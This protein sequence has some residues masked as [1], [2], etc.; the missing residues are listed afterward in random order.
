MVTKGNH[1]V[2]NKLGKTYGK[3][4]AQR[5][6]A[7][8][9]K[10]ALET[11]A[12][13]AAKEYLMEPSNLPL[14]WED[15][16]WASPTDLQFAP[17]VGKGMWKCRKCGWYTRQGKTTFEDIH[18]ID[19]DQG[20]PWC[21]ICGRVASSD[22]FLSIKDEEETKHRYDAQST[23]V[24][25]GSKTIPFKIQ[26]HDPRGL[27]TFQ[28]QWAKHEGTSP[29]WTYDEAEMEEDMF[30]L[31]FGPRPSLRSILATI[32][33]IQGDKVPYNGAFKYY[34][35]PP[36]SA[37]EDDDDDDTFSVDYDEDESAFET[38]L[39]SNCREKIIPAICNFGYTDVIWMEKNGRVIFDELYGM[40]AQINESYSYYS[41]VAGDVEATWN[42]E[43]RRGVR[44][45]NALNRRG[46][47]TCSSHTARWFF[48][49]YCWQEFTVRLFIR[50]PETCTWDLSRLLGAWFDL[51]PFSLSELA[52]PIR[53]A[54]PMRLRT[55]LFSKLPM[56]TDE[57]GGW[58]FK[59]IY[60][61]AKDYMKE[62]FHRYNKE[63]DSSRAKLSLISS[64]GASCRLLGGVCS[65]DTTFSGVMRRYISEMLHDY[66]HAQESK[67]KDM[68]CWF[69]LA[70]GVAAHH[71]TL[72]AGDDSGDYE[73]RPATFET[74]LCDE[75]IPLAS[76]NLPW[77]CN[78]LAN[79][80]TSINSL[81]VHLENLGHEEA[82]VVEG[83]N[84]EL[85]PFQRQTLQWALEREKNPGGLQSFLW[86]KLPHVADEKSPDLY[87]N[88]LLQSITTKK[89]KLVRGGIIAEEMGLGKTVR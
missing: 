13:L 75:D 66:I 8:L 2:W 4:G 49:F 60:D 47:R 6:I 51:F 53:A 79:N 81:L 33:V 28:E 16:Q 21:L 82:P 50:Q 65:S 84:V 38:S 18:N 77:E 63:V 69:A 7:K 70:A 74:F 36:Q 58:E 89:P 20:G 42:K 17:Y 31:R 10:F 44:T 45:R 83:L 48:D 24:Y 40:D 35:K 64:V 26:V 72:R 86:A 43:E 11:V 68:L 29:E 56:Q 12:N 15:I 37:Y 55:R 57:L 76:E 59:A 78:V 85:L 54:I 19:S 32:Q 9:E 41:P 87:Y 67:D 39:P 71:R 25:L 14:E 1:G 52:G 27:K 62:G 46:L 23:D 73:H 22:C 34:V 88:P 61:T 30:R 5:D 80:T 3:A